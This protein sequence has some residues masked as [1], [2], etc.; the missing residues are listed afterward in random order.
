[1]CGVNLC[2][3]YRTQFCVVY[4]PKWDYSVR[5]RYGVANHYPFGN[6]HTRAEYGAIP[7]LFGVFALALNKLC[8]LLNLLQLFFC[9]FVTIKMG[10]TSV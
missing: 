6:L 2:S 8:K 1:M 3:I 10:G 9:V 4:S 5:V 7:H